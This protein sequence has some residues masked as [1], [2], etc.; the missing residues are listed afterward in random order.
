MSTQAH[1]L[2]PVGYRVLPQRPQPT[3]H[4]HL[5]AP[6]ACPLLAPS[7]IPPAPPV[8]PRRHPARTGRA[9][10]E[11]S[12][13]AGFLERSW[14]RL[15]PCSPTSCLGSDASCEVQTSARPRCARGL[16]FPPFAD[17]RRRK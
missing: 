4:P 1:H 13:D 6:S 17:D 11:S 15:S 9:W 14:V 7:D 2:F 10:S 16:S 12:R 8:F 5:T 3:L